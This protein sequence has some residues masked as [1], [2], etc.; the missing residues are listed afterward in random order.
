MI[1]ADAVNRVKN[2]QILQ[3]GPLFICLFP[4]GQGHLD[5]SCR[6]CS[7]S[8]IYANIL[9]S[10]TL[11]Q[12][13]EKAHT[14]CSRKGEYSEMCRLLTCAPTRTACVILCIGA[15]CVRENLFLLGIT[16]RAVFNVYQ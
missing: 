15:Q 2:N 13:R 4:K 10:K 11:V 7:V 9:E 1:E 14:D 6:F 16:H 3:L 12:L 5:L 8:R